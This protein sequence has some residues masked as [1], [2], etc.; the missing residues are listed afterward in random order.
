VNGDYMLVFTFSNTL[1][2]VGSPSVMSGTGSVASS[3]IDG[4]DA[5]NYLVNLTGVTNAQYLTVRLTNVHDSAGNGSNV[6]STSMGVL[7]GDTNG[8]GVVNGADTAQTKSQSGTAVTGSNF[9]EDVNTDGFINSADISLVK[10]KSGTGLGNLRRSHAS[11]RTV[12]RK[13]AR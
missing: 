1:T 7:L 3:K 2:Y 5:H 11:D 12:K 6:V 9:R 10:S 13:S 8:D 4:N